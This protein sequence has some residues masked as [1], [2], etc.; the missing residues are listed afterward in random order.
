MIR[1]QCPRCQGLLQVPP[2]MA[3]QVVACG[4]CR[5][6]MRVPTSA[7]QPVGLRPPGASPPS[8]P[9][10]VVQAPARPPQPPLPRRE[11][12]P[13]RAQS[14]A[15]HRPAPR[16]GKGRGLLVA[17]L[18]ALALLPALAGGA[19]FFLRGQGNGPGANVDQ[20]ETGDQG[21]KPEETAKGGGKDNIEAPFDAPGVLEAQVLDALNA[22]R[23]QAGVAPVV[24]DQARSAGC[25]EHAR[26][27][28]RNA[29]ARAAQ[30]A[31]RHEQVSGLPGCS[32]AGRDAAR[33]ASVVER[34]PGA[35]LAVWLAAPAH[36]AL[37]LHPSLKS[38][39]LGFV[40]GEGERWASA[41]DWLSGWE[42]EPGVGAA[43]AVI[44]PAHKQ[45]RVPLAFPGNEIPD[46]V[47]LAKDKLTGYPITMTFLG[48]GRPTRVRGWLEDES[49]A[50]VEVWFSSP[51][52]PANKAHARS[53]Q[54]TVCLM[55]HRRLVPG[56]RYVVHVQAV[57]VG[58]PW[59]RTLSFTTMS[60]ADVDGPLYG[61]ALARLNLHRKA[62]GLGEVA[63]DE[64]RSGACLA[65]ARYVALNIN[66]HPKL[67]VLDEEPTLP[68]YT[69][70]GKQVA[71][72]SALRLGGGP[73]APDAVDWLLGSLLNRNVVLN[74]GLEKMGMGAAQ[75]APRGWV[76][77]MDLS[78]P[79]STKG[80][81]LAV[82]HP[83]K[84]QR[85]VPLAYGRAV[86]DLVGPEGKDKVAGYAISASFP[87]RA[88]VSAAT[89][90]LVDGTGAE[91]PFWLSTPARPFGTVRYNLLGVLPKQPLRPATTYAV[92]LRA[93]VNGA[94]W[95]ESWSFRT[96]DAERAR[97]E[98]AAELVRQVNVHRGR[99]GL[100]PVTLDAKVSRGCLLHA[101]Y[102][103]LNINHPA[104]Q[105]L[106]IHEEDRRL[107]GVT[108]EG[109]KAGKG[110]VIAI[111]SDPVESVD[112]WMATL[113]HRVPLLDPRLKRIGYGQALV[114]NRGWVTVLDADSGRER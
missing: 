104:V 41:F 67:N 83:G 14:S 102:V 12:A 76:W 58:S 78:A 43:P 25:R 24:P 39:G 113:Y 97:I 56:L 34:A 70:E 114:V 23:A 71:R 75:Q 96:L 8:P 105:G 35:A 47:P 6:Q 31:G 93:T 85:D 110:A 63:L 3:G 65:H 17:V 33:R 94:P 38:V 55:A 26:Y 72:R 7:T 37:L 77:A 1:I 51:E 32:K 92:S 57:V 66:D 44:Y 28:L 5:Q 22:A 62:T 64:E 2:S 4:R 53:Q 45:A 19:F 90:Q 87:P 99:A 30:A 101:R 10:P 13:A 20:R 106:G 27:W 109:T 16:P 84:G 61:G 36:R 98:V 89:A 69:K 18:C 15:P 81:P 88:P 100:A 68:G 9:S 107:P 108:P 112:G 103:S 86:P 42:G 11:P 95:A 49:G 60:E 111:I 48:K 91:V 59:S 29:G 50:P 54:N 80:A 52:G 40:R 73:G 21:Q 46:P 74:P 82:L 79:R